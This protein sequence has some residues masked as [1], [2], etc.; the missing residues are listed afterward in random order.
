MLAPRPR[1]SAAPPS[2]RDRRVSAVSCAP[3]GR[4]RC[5]Q[6]RGRPNQKDA[7]RGSNDSDPRARTPADE[8]SRWRKESRESDECT[9]EAENARRQH[10]HRW[11]VPSGL[12]ATLL[13]GFEGGE[14]IHIEL[15]AGVLI[16]GVDHPV[17]SAG[18]SSLNP[19]PMPDPPARV[20]TPRAAEV[21][22]DTVVLNRSEPR[23]SHLSGAA[24]SALGVITVV[25]TISAVVTTLAFVAG[26][27]GPT[28]LHFF[29]GT[30]DPDR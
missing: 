20:V 12:V 30:V 2:G 1:C 15:G 14:Q 11:P 21:H 29:W 16:H 24:M 8:R 28:L 25:G 3:C 5:F 27:A 22:W 9:P 6:V 7:G 10:Q 19:R 18:C 17:G 23:R 26:G 13:C 4:C